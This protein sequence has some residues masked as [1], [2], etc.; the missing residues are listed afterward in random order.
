MK[1]FNLSVILLSV[2]VLSPMVYAADL[3]FK[4]TDRIGRIVAVKRHKDPTSVGYFCLNRALDAQGQMDCTVAQFAT[5][6]DAQ[7]AHDFLLNPMTVGG[8]WTP[9]GPQF[10]QETGK[11]FY[12]QV[13]AS[14]SGEDFKTLFE[15][16]NDRSDQDWQLKPAE[17]RKG[18]IDGALA[19]LRNGAPGKTEAPPVVEEE[20]KLSDLMCAWFDGV[21]VSPQGWHS[22]RKLKGVIVS[23][24]YFDSYTV[25]ETNCW[26][27][28]LKI[29]KK[30]SR[31]QKAAKETCSCVWTI[32]TN[33][34][35][36]GYHMVFDMPVIDGTTAKVSVKYFDSYGNSETQ[37]NRALAKQNFDCLKGF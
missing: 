12:D 29:S 2:G 10:T 34:G 8:E 1:S 33:I 15:A 27:S 18:V 37:C 22:Y 17:L 4:S 28:I 23:E 7:L 21:H 5:S 19:I 9:V 31:V 16:M 3:P 14:D 26:Q 11:A 24:K 35:L 32:G 6:I 30:D 20:S 25:S 13:L 36:Q